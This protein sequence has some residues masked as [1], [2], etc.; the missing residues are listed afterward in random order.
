MCN[1]CYAAQEDFYYQIKFPINHTWYHAYALDTNNYERFIVYD[2]SNQTLIDTFPAQYYYS[3]LSPTQTGYVFANV[4]SHQIPLSTSLKIELEVTD[5]I[6]RPPAVDT[7]YTENCS[8][9]ND[10]FSVDDPCETG[11]DCEADFTYQIIHQ[12]DN[13]YLQ[14]SPTSSVY[15]NNIVF[16][17][18]G[19]SPTMLPLQVLY[20]GSYNVLIPIPCADNC[21]LITSVLVTPEGDRCRDKE[22]V[23]Y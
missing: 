7:I 8:G 9:S 15:A 13:C 19:L 12:G 11:P 17:V 10:S 4:W 6:Y 3:N 18:S 14:L 21:L 22:I 20:Q 16:T 1:G 23:C 5:F 2:K